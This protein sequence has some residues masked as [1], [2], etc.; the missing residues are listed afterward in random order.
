MSWLYICNIGKE[1]YTMRYMTG[2][3]SERA[4]I[5][6]DRKLEKGKNIE[7]V[8]KKKNAGSIYKTFHRRIGN[9]SESA[10][11]IGTVRVR[12]SGKQ[13]VQGESIVQ[14][15]TS[16]STR[17]EM[18]DRVRAAAVKPAEKFQR[19]KVRA[20]N[21]HFSVGRRVEREVL[22]VE[23]SQLIRARQISGES[24]DKKTRDRP[25]VVRVITEINGQK[26]KEDLSQ[27]RRKVDYGLV[28]ID[29][30]KHRE[31]PKDSW[32]VKKKGEAIGEIRRFHETQFARGGKYEK[33]TFTPVVYDA[34]GRK[35][36]IEG[37]VIID[38]WE[39]GRRSKKRTRN[40][41]G[42]KRRLKKMIKETQKKPK[43]TAP[44]R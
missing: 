22:V 5:L 3:I 1:W 43:N 17:Q 14:L 34:K 36:T 39:A 19:T 33:R 38:V 41:F 30:R 31:T 26:S 2:T 27:G 7:P 6:K 35:Q 18:A 32:V 20:Y 42:A 12:L 10:E 40:L 13:G 8:Y 16:N 24:R 29:A 28:I 44:A 23:N 9:V 37:G 11:V 4:T 21:W 15:T 25:P